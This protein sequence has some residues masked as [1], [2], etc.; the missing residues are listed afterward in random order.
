MKKRLFI[1]L[2]VT[3]IACCL[4]ALSVSAAEP[5]YKDGEW[6]YAADGVTKL[7][8]YDTDG[9]PLIWYMNG[10]TLKY[11]RADQTDT[12]QSVYVVYKIEAGGNGFDS[13]HT[14]TKCLKDIDIYDNGTRI[15]GATIN[16][17]IVLFNAINLDVDA[18]NGWLFGNKNG[19]C[20]I[21]RG[22]VFPNTIKYIGQEGLT[23]TKMVQYWNFENTKFEWINSSYGQNPFSAK[24]LTQEATNYTL[25]YP[26]TLTTITSIAFSQIKTVILS[27]NM[28][29]NNSSQSFRG[30][31]Q[32]EKIFVP[33]T[34][35]EA[36]F[37]NE[38]FRDISSKYLVFITGTEAQAETLQTNTG[39]S[40]NG[41]FKNA[42]RISYE[43][44]LADPSTYDD[45]TS[46][47]YLIYD[48]NYCDAFYE[49][50]HNFVDDKDCTTPNDCSR[51]C[52]IEVPKGNDSHANGETLTYANGFDKPGL[53]CVGCMNDGCEVRTEETKNPIFT[54]KGYSTNDAKNALNGGFTVDTEALEFY[55]EK[56]GALVY[57]IVIA[58][59]NSFDGKSFFDENNDVN[60][61]KAIKAEIDTQYSMFDCEINFGSIDAS[62][63][64]LII[65]A[66]VIDGDSV[67]F[68]QHDSGN[69]VSNSAISDGS[70][71]SITLEAVIALIPSASKEN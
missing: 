14:P 42:T 4:F 20:T 21:M 44:Y 37:A 36:G 22:L 32:L 38:A 34:F 47:F 35:C 56:N 8:M 65:C 13:D 26:E 9:N 2:I 69:D 1:F 31:S 40:Y 67:S 16:S 52:G 24:T 28:A 60:S 12:T 11:V 17:Q 3:V 55:T 71:K 33:T 7:T 68:I 53:F 64:E 39:S 41:A 27:P 6:I 61:E 57:G 49:K 48:T 54:A 19:C 62:A 59:A 30:C 50:N 10:E 45:S 43:T 66:Y 15:E 46:T 5:S 29:V 18:F 58:N 51:A 63:L 25:K 23:N 70:F